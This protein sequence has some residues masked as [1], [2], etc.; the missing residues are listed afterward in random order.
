MK[1][2]I[3]QLVIGFT[4]LVMALLMTFGDKLINLL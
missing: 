4:C 3:L 2:D 1:N